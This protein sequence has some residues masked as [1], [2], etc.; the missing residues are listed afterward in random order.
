MMLDAW[1]ARFPEKCTTSLIRVRLTFLHVQSCE[2]GRDRARRMISS[3]TLSSHGRAAVAAVA[4]AL[5]SLSHEA[6][7]ED[8]AER[9]SFADSRSI[10]Q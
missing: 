8:L 3:P 1:S 6:P 5:R 7:C 4:A 10:L 2:L 9:T